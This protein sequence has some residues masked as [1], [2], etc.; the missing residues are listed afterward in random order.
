MVEGYFIATGTLFRT[1]Q[2]TATMELC[3][4]QIVV[5]IN[6]AATGF[7]YA[8]VGAP[9]WNG[10]ILSKLGTYYKGDSYIGWSLYVNF[11]NTVNR[12][13]GL[14]ATQVN[15]VVVKDTLPDN[16]TDENTGDKSDDTKPEDNEFNDEGVGYNTNINRVFIFAGLSARGILATVIIKRKK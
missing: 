14:T 13:N 2:E 1:E 16:S 9:S 4:Q 7:P 6:P 5:D 3:G 10:G 8:G 12:A 11:E 15:N